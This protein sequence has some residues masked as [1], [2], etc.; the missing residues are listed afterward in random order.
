[1]SRL[2]KGIL[3]GLVLVSPFWLGLAWLAGWL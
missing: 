1:M 3:V 2:V